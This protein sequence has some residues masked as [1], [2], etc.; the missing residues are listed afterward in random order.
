MENSL[1]YLDI[2]SDKNIAEPIESYK[3][4]ALVDTKRT[5]TKKKLTE[6]GF[7]VTVIGK[8]ETSVD[9]NAKEGDELL[10]HDRLILLTDKSVMTKIKGWTLREDLKLGE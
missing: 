5:T 10:A 8:G 3:V 4:P 1:H 9:A 7:K 2:E 6:E